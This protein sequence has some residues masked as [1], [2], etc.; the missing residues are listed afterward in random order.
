MSE[1]IFTDEELREMG[2]RTLD[3]VLEAIDAGDK[4]KAKAL[5]KRMKEE[6]NFLHDGYFFWVTGLQTY[7]YKNY[8][9]DAV[10][11]AEREAH[12]IEAKVVFKP[13]E[14]TDIRSRVEHLASG[15][16]GHMQPIEIV[17]DDKNILLTLSA[18]LRAEGHEVVAAQD[19]M[20]AM[21]VAVRAKPDL[22]LLDISIPAG[23]GFQVD[24]RVQ[25]TGS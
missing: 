15:L 3:L 12:N 23:N 9:I 4:E 24:G 14:K 10:E 1:R 6:F 11:E 16:R 21:S 7:I 20:M 25:G 5:A 22:A 8:G 13:P 19:A 17:E 18:R 2:T